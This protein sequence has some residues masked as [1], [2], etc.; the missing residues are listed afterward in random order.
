M[1]LDH[2]DHLSGIIERLDGEVDRLMA[3]FTE[4]ATRLLSVPGI[5][6]RSAEVIV[7]E[8]GVDMSR[9]P[10]PAHWRPGPGCAPATTIG[11]QTVLRQGPM[12]EA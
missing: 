10:T 5:A 8:I 2:V 3:P 1:H 9:F 11:W 7:A 6:K 4:A 12:G